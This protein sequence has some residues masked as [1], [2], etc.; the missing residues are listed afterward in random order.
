[1]SLREIHEATGAPKGS[2]STWLAQYPLTTEERKQR[3]SRVTWPSRKKDR[4]SE[5]SVS[6]VLTSQ[7]LTKERIAEAATF[8]RL[9]VHGFGV[10]GSCFDG[11][12]ADWVVEIPETK[13]I[14]KIQ[15]KSC[16]ADRG[17]PTVSLRHAAGGRASKRYQ[18][19]DYD[20]LVGYDLYTDVCYV[21]SWSETEGNS[22][23][24]TIHPE[25]AE[26]WDKLRS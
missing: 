1:M 15:V 25:A 8:F 3:R 21:W 10:F 12:R 14:V 11:D 5:S 4:G 16:K 2:L 17:L 22:T 24:I 7:K 18:K 6:K 23:R 26:R 19:G 20:F 13:R 9:A